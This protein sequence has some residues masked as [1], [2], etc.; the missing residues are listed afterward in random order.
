MMTNVMFQL[1]FAAIAA[2]EAVS[3]LENPSSD[4]PD[5]DDPAKTSPNTTTP[6]LEH[7]LLP[8]I[9]DNVLP[10]NSAISGTSPDP[11]PA[12]R[13]LPQTELPPS[14]TILPTNQSSVPAM[15]ASTMPSLR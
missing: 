14:P 8:S 2:D 10:T 13:P 9:P 3:P 12:L 11:T 6:P 4:G 5:I 7:V 15:P 1:R